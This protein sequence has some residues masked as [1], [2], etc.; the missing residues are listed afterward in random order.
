MQCIDPRTTNALVP[1]GGHATGNAAHAIDSQPP[2]TSRRHFLLQSAALLTVTPVLQPMA[3]AVLL[4][5]SIF[6]N[7]RYTS[8]G[9]DVIA[10]VKRRLP[11][12]WKATLLAADGATIEGV[13]PQLARLPSDTSH[14]VL[15]AGGNNALMQ[16][17]ILDQ[18]VR[19]TSEALLLLARAVQ[20]FEAAY[21][22]VIGLCLK[23]GMP[24]TICTIYNGNFPD[25]H[26][27]RRASTALALF[28]DAIVRVGTENQLSMIDLRHICNR[29]EDYANPIEPSSV[30]GEKIARAI[31]ALLTERKA[32]IPG[33]RIVGF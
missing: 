32:N 26:F 8:G 22:K 21:R 19:S 6:D 1:E 16:Q 4:G 7:G 31:T 30:G 24:L 27:Q 5:D 15:S 10:Q 29:P 2:P 18:P 13:L 20:E 11:A 25:T 23:P 28:N 12:S 14:L 9:P 33:A 3:H 17:G